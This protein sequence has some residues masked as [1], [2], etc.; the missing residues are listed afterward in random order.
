V[1]QGVSR[2]RFLVTT[3]AAVPALLLPSLAAAELAPTRGLSF[4]H[5]HTSERLAIEY[6]RGG[7][8]VPEALSALSQLLRDFRTGEVLPIDPN[9]FDLLH[10]LWDRA[11]GDRPY[12]I[13][14]GYRSP[15]T[16][17]ALRERSSG[18]A[19][20]SLHMVGRA[21]DI[22]V[23]DVPLARLRDVALDLRLGGVGYYPGS[24]F[25]HV[26]TGRVRRW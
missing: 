14:S 12:Q 26:D 6:C 2:R 8:Y 10:Q 23:A 19:S 5:T 18:V 9:L 24:N 3:A 25:V 7:Q 20:G 21:I 17:A 16:N 15:A 1:P 22:R 13:I 4:V 11:G